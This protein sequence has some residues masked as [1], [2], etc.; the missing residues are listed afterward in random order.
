MHDEGLQSV[1]LHQKNVLFYRI[2]TLAAEHLF[3]RTPL[4]DHSSSVNA[5]AVVRR[6]SSKISEFFIKNSF[7]YRTPLVGASLDSRFIYCSAENAHLKPKY[8]AG[9]KTKRKWSDMRFFFALLLSFISF[10]IF[11]KHQLFYSCFLFIL[12]LKWLVLVVY[13]FLYYKI[14]TCRMISVFP[15]QVL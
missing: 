13:K 14:L 2:L 5:K 3:C 1:T 15:L 10:W 7:F 6:L 11:S 8:P 9:R 4:I 12:S